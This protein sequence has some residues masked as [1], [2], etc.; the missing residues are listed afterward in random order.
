MSTS[1]I[2]LVAQKTYKYVYKSKFQ[3]ENEPLFGVLPLKM[4]FRKADQEG[5]PPIKGQDQYSPLQ[6]NHTNSK[7]SNKHST[8]SIFTPSQFDLKLKQTY[9]FECH[10][11]SSPNDDSYHTLHNISSTSIFQNIYTTGTLTYQFNHN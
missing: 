11:Q 2:S 6:I 9:R 4:N 1:V 8:K 10:P 5:K 3:L 7:L